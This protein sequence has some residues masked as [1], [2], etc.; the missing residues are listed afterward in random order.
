MKKMKKMAALFLAIVMVLGMGSTV[1]AA[2]G[3]VTGDGEPTPPETSA[4]ISL[5][6][7]P[8]NTQADMKGHTF[9]AYQI[10]KAEQKEDDHTITKID[11]GSGINAEAFL[12]AL[13]TSTEFSGDKNPFAGIAYV[14]NAST[15]TG[16]NKSADAVARIVSE[17]T[18][19]GP[20]A[21]LFARIADQNKK[22]SGSPNGTN[23]DA[24]YYLVVD[25]T[26]FAEGAQN[27][28]R[29]LSILQLTKAHAFTP[30]NKTDVPEL[31]KKVKEKNDSDIT[32]TDQWGDVA[33]YDITDEVEFVLTG[34]LPADYDSYKVYKYVFRDTLGAALNLK[35]ESLVVKVDGKAVA[36]VTSGDTGYIFQQNG[37]SF[38]VTFNDLKKLA[39]SDGSKVTKDTVITVEY[40]ATFDKEK[41]VYG[42]SGNEN[43]AHLEYSNNPNHDGSGTPPTG[44]T[45][46]D[47][48]VVFTYQLIANK[49]DEDGKAL[50]GAG[51]TLYKYEKDSTEEDK[52]V[53]V[54]E[55]ITGVTEFKFQGVD[56]GR[57]KLVE[58]TVPAGYNKAE[59]M[60][61]TVVA[62][63]DE[64]GQSVTKL[65]ITEVTDKDG[66]KLTAADGT[67]PTFT[68][69][70]NV[71]DG[72]L[73]SNIVNQKGILL[74]STGG[75]G[76]TIFYVVG[77]ILIF[78]AAILLVVKKRMSRAE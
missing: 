49:K 53:Q 76:T 52:Y 24:G 73:T 14:A 21:R 15:V 64:T 20:D 70:G 3:D 2:S 61:F 67:T 56:A 45:P 4:E 26:E 5:P 19:D 66:N 1:F 57:Y 18:A 51:F 36:S 72:S 55:E 59:D 42:G 34:T 40:K 23:L 43:K 32:I 31:E 58:T 65:E 33:D 38:S 12:T 13:Q 30:E 37:Q 60:Y 74:P 54:G 48:V 44:D 25:E 46:D 75:I 39:L 7:K 35:A 8:N 11:W 50:A 77:S 6:E 28:V 62:E 41:V 16:V 22:G 17:W 9:T 47:K 63:L 78:G 71:T 69:T 29:N 68:F 10:F 27:T